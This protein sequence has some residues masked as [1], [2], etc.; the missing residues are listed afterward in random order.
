MATI[1]PVALI[2]N[3]LCSID[4]YPY[5]SNSSYTLNGAQVLECTTQKQLRDNGGSASIILA[6]GGPNG[7]G[8]PSWAQVIT[9]QS[10]VVIAMQRGYKSNVVFVGVVREVGEAESW[11][12]GPGVSRNTVITAMDWGAWFQDFNWSALTF[13]AVTNGAAYAA[14]QQLPPEMGLPGLELG[15]IGS[16]PG[17]IA[18][19]WYSKI[20]GG[21]QGILS[22]TQIQY[23]GQ[24]YSWPT[25]T[26]AFFEDYPYGATWPSANYYISQAGSWYDKFS[27]IF[28]APYYELIVGTAPYG[29]WNPSLQS[30]SPV[31]G[32]ST[33]NSKELYGVAQGS[34]S[35]N[36]GGTAWVSPGIPFTS[37][38]LP[39][40][41]PA[42]AQVVGRVCPLPDLM[43]SDQTQTA[44]GLQGQQA[45]IY[46]GVDM[47]RWMSLQYYELD[48]DAG[49]NSSSTALV[50]Q[51]Y[52]NFFVLNPT[53][54]KQFW[55]VD[56]SPGVFMYA[57]S[58]AANVAGIHR[59]GYRAMIR[60]T[61]WLVDQNYVVS[62]SEDPSVAMQ[63]LV[64]GLTTRLATFYTPTAIME[65]ANVIFRLSP[66]NFVGN[67]FTYSPFRGDEPWT[68]YIN[69]VTHTWKFGG[70][71]LTTLGLERG[72][73]QSVYQNQA[74][75]QQVLAGNAQR[76]K[77]HIV[78]GLPANSGPALQ[79]FGLAPDSVTTVLGQIAQIYKTPG[80][81]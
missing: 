80:G 52:Y 79:T 48:L 17:Q 44:T 81:Q 69:S 67:V 49:F 63:N 34:V 60:D 53:A 10:L 32:Q 25:A 76:L 41:V 37:K 51:D 22:G 21:T 65:S 73:P 70:P 1:S 31:Q 18:S 75:M 23:A 11:D 35:L 46:S 62:E 15:L 24:T 40:A 77:G 39:N 6:P 54:I 61:M 47:S 38:G 33:V 8:F 12:T 43:V 5:E 7:Q 26:T 64:A 78:S 59:F 27:E 74:I 42:Y 72:L 29:A 57:Y 13:L 36:N 19:G 16:N 68:F 9:L 66:D 45:Y 71:S 58:G 50:L 4:I 55:K 2:S 20:M 56:S 30:S 14:S 3:P 28:E